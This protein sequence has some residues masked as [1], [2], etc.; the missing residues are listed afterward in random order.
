MQNSN[1][2]HTEK[3]QDNVQ[4]QTCILCQSTENIITFKGKSICKHCVADAVAM[5]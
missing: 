1:A 3:S 4:E 5:R 2:K